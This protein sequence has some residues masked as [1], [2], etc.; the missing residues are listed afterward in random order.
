MPKATRKST[1]PSPVAGAKPAAK[2]A[3]SVPASAKSARKPAAKSAVKV[4]IAKKSKIVKVAAVAAPKAKKTK[5]VRDSFNMP[6]F[7][8][9]LIGVLKKRALG[10]ATEV[11]KSELLRAGLKSLAAMNDREFSAALMA[12]HIVKT[13]RP[14]KKK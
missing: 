1:N 14:G 9:A 4:P 5:T 3:L 12:V 11:K 13:G 7:D 6:D 8:Y 10:A 2:K